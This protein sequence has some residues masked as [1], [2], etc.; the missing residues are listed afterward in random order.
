MQYKQNFYVWLLGNKNNMNDITVTFS[1]P[2]HVSSMAIKAVN[3][4]SWKDARLTKPRSTAS[5]IP[6]FFLT[7]L[8]NY[9]IQ[10]LIIH[11]T[12]L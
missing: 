6:H 7:L 1:S 3:E 8:Q 10:V 9:S 2:G 5:L 4:I 12:F 11:S